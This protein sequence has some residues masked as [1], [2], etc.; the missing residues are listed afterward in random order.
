MDER[1]W[2]RTQ[3]L[4]SAGAAAAV[5]LVAAIAGFAMLE[6]V[7]DL[8]PGLA[9]AL[10]VAGLLHVLAGMAVPRPRAAMAAPPLALYLWMAWS[11]TGDLMGSTSGAEG[12]SL[13]QALGLLAVPALGLGAM[14]AGF[15]ALGAHLRERRLRRQRQSRPAPYP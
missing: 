7:D 14:L 9:L 11:W 12:L 13:A 5:T 3:A 2:G 10:C 15:V 4:A 6:A 8:L 1:E